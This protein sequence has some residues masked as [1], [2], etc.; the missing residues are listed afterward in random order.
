MVTKALAGT[1]LAI[2]AACISK[3]TNQQVK[4][5]TTGGGAANGLV[6][7]LIL[8]VDVAFDLFFQVSWIYAKHA[9]SE[10][11]VKLLRQTWCISTAATIST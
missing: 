2:E 1:V 8:H 7:I 10:R 6:Y 4:L 11:T 3:T 9:I 5:Y